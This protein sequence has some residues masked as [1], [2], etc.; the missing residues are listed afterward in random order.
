MH[1][2][3]L[4]EF[5]SRP[6]DMFVSTKDAVRFTS[7]TRNW[8]VNTVVDAMHSFAANRPADYVITDEDWNGHASDAMEAMRPSLTS[9]NSLINFIIE[10][11]DFKRLGADLVNLFK[12]RKA[13][14]AQLESLKRSRFIP[15]FSSRP[16][17]SKPRTT[18]QKVSNAWLEWKLAWQPFVSDVRKLV[19]GITS[20]EHDVR[21]FLQREGK[22]QQRYWGKSIPSQHSAEIILATGSYVPP[23]LYP[24]NN[25]DTVWR[26]TLKETVTEDPRFHAT[27]R[28]R[29]LLND[30]L[31]SEAKTLNGFLDRLGINGNPAILWNAIPFSFIVDWFVDIGGYLNKLRVDNVQPVTEISDF[32]SS[33]KA[34]RRLELVLRGEILETSSSA[35][36]YSAVPEETVLTMLSSWYRR[37]AT[38]PHTSLTMGTGLTG[39]RLVTAAALVNSLRR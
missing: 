17:N 8:A 3:T 4:T 7:N 14:E 22:Q 23:E 19:S 37:E 10:L 1:R 12:S 34:E 9:N 18:S 39:T 27:M 31:R 33:V 16:W 35:A 26:W 13:M 21:Q 32:C 29:Y 24:M 20:F 38:L 36:V 28:Y 25:L 5:G 15:L 30:R 11:K 2:K 6:A